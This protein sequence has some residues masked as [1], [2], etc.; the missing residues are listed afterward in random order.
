MILFTRKKKVEGIKIPLKNGIPT[1]FVYSVKY[2]GIVLDSKLYWILNH[3]GC[4]S[5]AKIAHHQISSSFRK[6]ES[7]KF[8]YVPFW[9]HSIERA[10][11]VNDLN[12]SHSRSAPG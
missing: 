7:F 2:L 12:S 9:V 4:G 8:E 10:F 3:G 11:Q 1:L 5:V 6:T